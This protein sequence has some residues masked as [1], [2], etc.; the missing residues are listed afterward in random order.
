V[1]KQPVVSEDTD[2]EE[3]VNFQTSGNVSPVIFTVPK[4]VYLPE[5]LVAKTV[6]VPSQ[7]DSTSCG[8]RVLGV[9]GPTHL[10]GTFII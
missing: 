6:S 4:L 9:K 10:R 2:D 7:R 5:S 8:W 1:R 3:E